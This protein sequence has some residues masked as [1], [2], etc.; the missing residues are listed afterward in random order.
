MN[1]ISENHDYKIEIASIPSNLGKGEILYFVC[2]TTGNYARILY[3]CYGSPIWKSRNAYSI[4]IYYRSQIHSKYDHYNNMYWD[5]EK[6]LERLSLE[7]KKSHY[8]GKLTRKLIR[9][10]KLED[11]KQMLDFKRWQLF[12]ERFHK[13]YN[14]RG[15]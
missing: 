11:R 2:P 8:K 7:V 4:R 13:D 6:D 1:T 12:T 9:I 10:Q 15:L 3:K 14:S 5:N